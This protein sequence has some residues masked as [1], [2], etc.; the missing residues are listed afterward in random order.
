MQLV[1]NNQSFKSLDDCQMLDI[2]AGCV[3]ETLQQHPIKTLI[4]GWVYVLGVYVG[5]ES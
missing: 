1:T 2:S 5:C 3:L 4:F